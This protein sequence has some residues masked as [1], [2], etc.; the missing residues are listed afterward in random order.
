MA[1]LRVKTVEKSYENTSHGLSSTPLCS[2][3]SGRGA[4]FP[5]L[6]THSTFF[7]LVSCLLPALTQAASVEEQQLLDRVNAMCRGDVDITMDAALREILDFGVKVSE[8]RPSAVFH[9][10]APPHVGSNVR[11][12]S[13]ASPPSTPSPCSLSQRA[14][15]PPFVC[16]I[17]YSLGSLAVGRQSFVLLPHSSIARTPGL[18]LL[19]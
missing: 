16:R 17:L 19:F 1:F 12:G 9:L 2:G 14:A 3:T 5:T 7:S 11:L 13:A 10:V 18:L 8:G 6:D 4:R 15:A